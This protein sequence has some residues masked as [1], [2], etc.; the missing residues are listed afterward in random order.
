MAMNK[1]SKG[2]LFT[3]NF[4]SG[5]FFV[6]SARYAQNLSELVATAISA[7]I[8]AAVILIFAAITKNK[9]PNIFIN[10]VMFA[11][12]L[13]AG[14]GCIASFFNAQNNADFGIDHKLLC[15][16]LLGCAVIY[17][18]SLKLNAAARSSSIVFAATIFALVL[19]LI[20]ALPKLRLS[21]IDLSFD[22][23]KSFDYCLTA[24]SNTAI[25]AVAAALLIKR[26][27][28]GFGGYMSLG[29]VCTSFLSIVLSILAICIGNVDAP[30]Y[31]E[32]AKAAQPFSV[33]SGEWIYIIIYGMLSVLCLSLIVNLAADCLLQVFPKIRFQTIISALLT[34][35][36]AHLMTRFSLSTQTVLAASSI[37]AVVLLSA[38]FFIPKTRYQKDS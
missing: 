24:I 37:G 15:A 9:K 31:F 28:S 20:G 3:L 21:R 1:I 12:L 30:T 23:K 16:V 4:T 17:C 2:Q 19:L 13:C 6:F 25:A 32:L 34:F 38:M 5:A 8:I 14:A 27:K 11:V 29:I 7:V 33:Q 36:C 18:A 35:V 22:L 10:A 26:P